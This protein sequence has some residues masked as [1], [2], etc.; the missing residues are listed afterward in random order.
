MPIF[1]ATLYKKYRIAK[2]NVVHMGYISCR[3]GLS[4]ATCK[5]LLD[6]YLSHFKVLAFL[7]LQH[8]F[9][10]FQTGPGMQSI[11]IS[12]LKSQLKL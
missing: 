4:K 9:F 1:G 3:I 6:F 10:I 8:F 12:M 5:T 2:H 7:F 11:K